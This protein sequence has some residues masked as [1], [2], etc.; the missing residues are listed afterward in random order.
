MVA[1]ELAVLVKVVDLLVHLLAR[2][3]I[4]LVVPE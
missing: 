4:R 2:I 1:S 3:E